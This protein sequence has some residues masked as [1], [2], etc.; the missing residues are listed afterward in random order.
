[1]VIHKGHSYTSYTAAAWGWS[2]DATCARLRCYVTLDSRGGRGFIA[3]SGAGGL[4]LPR[5]R[6]ETLERHGGEEHEAGEHVGWQMAAAD[7]DTVLAKVAAPYL[8]LSFYGLH[9]CVL[10]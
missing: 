5:E 10:R 7:S 6:E 4:V 3:A 8:L 9:S 1:M 2:G